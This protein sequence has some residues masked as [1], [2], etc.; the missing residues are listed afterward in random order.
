MI[1]GLG[2]RGVSGSTLR[3]INSRIGRNQGISPLAFAVSKGQDKV[4]ELLL[5]RED[6]NP[7]MPADNS[8]TPLALAVFQG[9][10]EVVK[11]LLGRE[12]VNPNV[13]NNDG[14]TK[15]RNWARADWASP[16]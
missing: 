1:T 10:D 8:I 2:G 6:V 12:G 9:R 13:P 16:G 4:V 7:N 15:P 5:G 3:Q 11:L 14:R